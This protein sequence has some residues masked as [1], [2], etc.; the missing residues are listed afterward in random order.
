[1]SVLSSRPLVRSWFSTEQK[2]SFY[3]KEEPNQESPKT[4]QRGREEDSDAAWW[5][6]SMRLKRE[7]TSSDTR[8][9]TRTRTSASGFTAVSEF[10]LRPFPYLDIYSDI[11]NNCFINLTEA[12]KKGCQLY[13]PWAKTW[14]PKR[15][16]RSFSAEIT[17]KIWALKGVWPHIQTNMTKWNNSVTSESRRSLLIP[18]PDHTTLCP[19]SSQKNRL[20]RD[21]FWVLNFTLLKTSKN[22]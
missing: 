6:A 14:S 13:G 21:Y 1:M 11:Q 9:R 10:A 3:F 15:P 19:S 22:L 2:N 8:T 12:L 20:P 5:T 17:L 18:P 16:R 4:H 7:V